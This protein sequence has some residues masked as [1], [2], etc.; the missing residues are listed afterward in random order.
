VLRFNQFRQRR[1]E[2]R[3]LL[4]K[5][6]DGLFPLFV[7]GRLIFKKELERFNEL[8]RVVQIRVENLFV[9]LPE[10]GARRRLKQNVVSRVSGGKLLLNFLRQILAFVFRF[11]LA[12]RQSEFVNE[13]AVHTQRVF[14]RALN[15]PFG[16]ELPIKLIA[17][18]FEQSLKSRAHR[19]FMLDVDR[20]EL[21]ERL[22][23]FRDGFVRGFQLQFVHEVFANSFTATLIFYVFVHPRLNT[24]GGLLSTI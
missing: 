16:N 9:V 11:P 6:R 5:I 14:L 1:A 8:L 3:Q 21:F 24:Y 23:I 22:V 13:R 10:N 17:A 4:L 15:R 19:S 18:S 12:V 7:S 20:F 2:L